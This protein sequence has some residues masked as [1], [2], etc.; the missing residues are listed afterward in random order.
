MYSRDINGAVLNKVVIDEDIKATFDR[1]DEKGKYRLNNYIRFGGGDHNLRQNKPHYFYP[2]YVSKDMKHITLKEQTNYVKVLPITTAGQE[3]TWKTTRQTFLERYKNGEIIPAKENSKVQIFEKYREAQILKTVWHKPKYHAIH[4]G[5]NL[6]SKLIGQSFFDFPKS[7]NL[8]VDIL[9]ITTSP[10]DIVLDFFAGS[11]TTAHAVMKLNAEDASTDSRQVG[12]R[13]FI[14]VQ[15]PEKCD[16]KS[17]ALKAGYENIADI[18]KERI[19][20]AGEKIKE[21]N[22][23]VTANLD[24]GFRVLKVDSSNMADVYY[25]PDTTE[26]TQLSNLTENI[27]PERTPEDLLFQVL[28][29]WGVNLTLPITTETVESLKVF[30]VGGPPPCVD[31]LLRSKWAD[32]RGSM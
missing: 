6:V 16:E 15:L 3:R 14:M 13:K 2:I 4:H 22:T 25:T 8:I 32:H 21:E 27:K 7:L 9:K 20:R 18:S 12:G 31:R 19:R 23:E 17:E 11:S 5:T 29:N 30:F 26:Q 28:L 24:T 10:D 1:I